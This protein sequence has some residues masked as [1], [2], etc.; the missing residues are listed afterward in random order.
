MA[1][2]KVVI[3]LAVCLIGFAG[4]FCSAGNLNPSAPPG[5]TMKTLDEVEPATV[6]NQQNTPGGSSYE[7]MINQPGSY[8]LTENVST[9][10]GGI[11]VLTDGVTIDLKGFKLT[12]TNTSVTRSGVYATGH[13]N[14][15]IRNGTFEGFY[16]GV[17]LTNADNSNNIITGIK[18]VSNLNDGIFCY[19]Y[20]LDPTYDG[21]GFIVTD[22]IAENNGDDGIN[23]GGATVVTRC[24]ARNNNGSGLSADSACVIKDCSFYHNEDYGCGVNAGSSIIGCASVRNSGRGFTLNVN[25]SIIDC[26][27]YDNEEEGILT[28][29]SAVVEKCNVYSNASRGIKTGRGSVVRKCSSSKNSSFGIDTGGGCTIIGNSVFNNY[30]NGIQAGEGNVIKDNSSYHNSGTG[31]SAAAYGC[32]IVGNSARGNGNYGIYVNRYCVIDQNACYGNNQAGGTYANLYIGVPSTC[33]TGIN[34]AP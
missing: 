19:G 17:S 12:C 34:V 16:H 29:D 14:I 26:T 11:A 7:F 9:A 15:E 31:I 33:A 28:N 27:A 8:I 1:S 10:K 6:L 2:E 22:C 23:V 20:T 24:V 4:M 32:S 21:G 30:A 3:T 5:S 18:A 25:C 13:G